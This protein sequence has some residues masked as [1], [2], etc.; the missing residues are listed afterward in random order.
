MHSLE[1]SGKNK[2]GKTPLDVLLQRRPDLEHIPLTCENTNTPLPYIDLVNEILEYYVASN[3]LAQE[4]AKNTIDITAEELSVN[5]QYTIDVAYTKVKDAVYP[6]SLPFNRPIE[7][8]RTYLEHLGSSRYQ[9]MDIFKGSSGP[10][11]EAIACE[12]LKISP[13]ERQI[14]L[15]VALQPSKQLYEFYGYSS[16]TVFNQDWKVHLAQVP[17][18]LKQT[19]ISY[20]DLIELLKTRFLNPNQ[21][22]NTQITLDT[23]VDKDPC[24]LN[25]VTIKPLDD[26]TLQKMHRF[27]RLWRKLGWEIRD[28]DK[29]IQALGAND[30]NDTF[31]SKLAQVKQLQTDLKLPLVQL[32]GFW[33]NID[34]HSGDALY[35]K[36]FQNK[37]V[38][39]PVDADFALNPNS[40]ELADTS[41]KISEHTPTILAAL[42]IN[43]AEL[44]A[45]RTDAD[46]DDSPNATRPNTTR[47]TFAALNLANLSKLY[48]LALLAKALKLSVKDLISLKTLTGINPFSAPGETVKFVEK[49]RKVRQSHFSV[50]KLNYLYRHI[51]EPVGSIAPLQENLSLLVK[52]LRDGL[53]KIADDNHLESDPN[54]ELTRKK[55]GTTWESALVDQF[56]PM[57]DGSATYTT[58]LDS[59]PSLTFPDSVT[60]NIFHYDA[61]TNQLR[62]LGE[63]TENEKTL[64]LCFARE[65]NYQIA[66]NSLFQKSHVIPLPSLPPIEFPDSLTNKIS[67]DTDTKQ[68]QFVGQMTEDEKEL[69]LSLST[70]E[71]YL[72]AVNIIQS[73]PTT[74]LDSLPSIEPHSVNSNIS[75]ESTTHLLQVLGEMTDEEKN[76]VGS[77]SK[78]PNYL[79]ALD[80]LFNKSKPSTSPT[81]EASLNSLPNKL[82][83][84]ISGNKISYN[85]TTQIL[86]FVGAMTVSERTILVNLSNDKAY[87]EAIDN[88]FQRPRL[89]IS[90]TV[91]NTNASFLNSADAIAQLLNSGMLSAEEKFAYVLTRLLPYL[92][93][94]LS[95]SLIKQTLSDALK[96]D[97]AVT[98][99]LLESVLKAYTDASKPAIADFLAL[100]GDGLKA[101][102]F[103][104]PVLTV[105]PTVTRIEPTVNF[106]WGTDSP[107]VAIAQ[108]AFSVRWTGKLLAEYDETY[109]F[110]LR[111][112]GSMELQVNNQSITDGGTV[113]LKAGQLYDITVTYA[114]SDANGNASAQLSWSSPSTPKAIIPQKQLY[115]GT[116]FTSF[117][118]PLKSYY[119]LHK[120]S[121]LVN[122][123]KITVKELVYLSDHPDDFKGVDSA[124]PADSTKFAPFNLNVLPLNPSNFRTAL[125][126]QWLRLSDLFALRDSLPNGEI[127]LMDVF[128]FA[129][130]GA[131]KS[132]LSR[133]IIKQ[134]ATDTSQNPGF[135]NLLVTWTNTPKDTIKQILLVDWT[136]LS[137]ASIK[138]QIIDPNRRLENF[139]N[140]LA[141]LSNLQILNLMLASATSWDAKELTDLI[142]SQGLTLSIPADFKNEVKLLTLQACLSLSKRLGVSIKQLFN[143]ATTEPDSTQAQDIIKTVKAKYE[144]EQWLIIAKP[145]SDRLRESQKSALIDYV[146]AK[147]E[148]QAL[149]ISDSNQLFEYFLI[150]VNMCACMATSRIKQAISSV[151]LFVQRCL[152]NLENKLNS[153]GNELPLTVQPDAINDH[154]WK[155]MKNYRV[156]EAN[157]KVFLY[158]ENWIEPDL[159][160][161]KS[162]FFKEMESQLLQ[163]DVTMDTAEQAF[164]NYLEKLDD[165]ARLDICGMY[166]QEKEDKEDKTEI[167]HVFGRTFNTPHIYYYRLLIVDTNVWTPWEKVNLDIEGNHLIPV[168]YNRRLYLFWPIFI[169]K[170]DEQQDSSQPASNAGKPG[171]TNEEKFQEKVQNIADQTGI[172]EVNIKFWFKMVDEWASQ[173]TEPRSE[174]RD[175]MNQQIEYSKIGVSL[176]PGSILLSSWMELY[177]LRHSKI[178]N[179]NT[180]SSNSGANSNQIQQPRKHWEIKLAWSEYKQNKWMPKQV[181]LKMLVTPAFSYT[182]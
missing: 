87:Q 63:M 26:T 109:T 124:N 19:R 54:G 32:L 103:N 88:L 6:L 17:E 52:N 121:L 61:T 53:N 115:A 28:L 33:A 73:N 136:R 68:L 153:Q 71:N 5:P 180:N 67:Y 165:V 22:S 38:L 172:N 123:F 128:E 83:F 84:P 45:M 20:L 166:W 157:R 130:V 135:I 36:L 86:Q 138:Q 42:R 25:N 116:T 11:E 7:V 60:N 152:M 179:D 47:P 143:W 62:F 170:A 117:D 76:K 182:T 151:Q 55:L 74:F 106:N 133:S 37:S 77:L 122:N 125:F 78:S 164:L 173:K 50:A 175:F 108:G 113:S 145:L 93:G 98:E 176:I 89:F 171:Q 35:L 102:Y 4:T 131:D 118:L 46:L 12:Y 132:K 29:V 114:K 97:S 1:K 30:I 154:D 107:D 70:E 169:E 112:E 18:F 149:G 23:P 126:D 168:V 57:L 59:L 134:L 31:L 34:A 141:K 65:G 9:V 69:L 147:P 80:N 58:K 40:L 120:V 39:N 95:R 21:G 81:Y 101:E 85:H 90:N 64:L 140:L 177:D 110:Y 49:V 82:T 181:S 104:N 139:V 150:D 41:K 163:N 14:L 91:S 146:L 94:L 156:W 162:P 105:P 8:A 155:W 75:Y 2:A 56:I 10:S 92:Q 16:A 111:K 66:V 167:L 137:E 142:G 119:L 127:G 161:N 27:I 48:R 99:L 15:G 100:L 43:A 144:D 13:Q 24:D 96:L 51:S 160:D 129:A 159:R 3:K 178:N 79:N 44:E 148:I 158:P 174:F 72:N